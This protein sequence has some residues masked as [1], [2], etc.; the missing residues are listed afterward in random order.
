[1]ATDS[2]HHQS[3]DNFTASEEGSYLYQHFLAGTTQYTYDT[4][5]DDYNWYLITIV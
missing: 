3:L 4:R 5:S 2:G 1:M